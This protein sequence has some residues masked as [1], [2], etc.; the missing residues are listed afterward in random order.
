MKDVNF[1]IV[2]GR[3]VGRVWA[4]E[5]QE[6]VKLRIRAECEDHRGVMVWNT[7]PVHIVGPRREELLEAEAGDRIFVEGRLRFFRYQREGEE[8][9]RFLAFVE[10]SVPNAVLTKNHTHRRTA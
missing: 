5:R 9:K 6:A 3:I 8:H 4:D 7:F 1:S 2:S 10:A